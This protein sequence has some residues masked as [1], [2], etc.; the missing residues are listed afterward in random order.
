[1]LTPDSANRS[2]LVV[3]SQQITPTQKR[4]YVIF[5]VEVAR[6]NQYVLDCYCIRAVR[7]YPK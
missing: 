3:S 5:R 4:S 2:A 1:M 7:K 6:N